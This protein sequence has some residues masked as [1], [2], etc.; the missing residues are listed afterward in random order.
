MALSETW[1]GTDRAVDTPDGYQLFRQDLTSHCGGVC[2]YLRSHYRASRAT[3]LCHQSKTLEILT[4]NVKAKRSISISVVYRHPKSTRSD[5]D[6][7]EDIASSAVA[8]NKVI[9]FLGDFNCDVSKPSDPTTSSLMRSFDSLGLHQLVK[10]PTRQTRL[11]STIIDLIY[12]GKKRDVLR[13]GVVPYSVSDHNIIYAVLRLKLPKPVKCS[14]TLRSLKKLDKDAYITDLALHDW[15]DCTRTRNVNAAVDAFTAGMNAAI[16]KH[17]PKKTVIIKSRPPAPWISDAIRMLMKDRERAKLRARNTG[18]QVHW[19]L[20]R[21]IRNEVNADISKAKQLH[22]ASALSEATTSKEK[23]QVINNLLCRKK[24]SDSN[25]TLPDLEDLN[26]YFA[27]ICSA[28]PSTPRTGKQH[29]STVETDQLWLQPVTPLDILRVIDAMPNKSSEG[30]DGINLQLLKFSL[31][32]TLPIIDHI[33][34]LSFSTATFPHQWKQA[35]VVPIYKKKGERDACSS[36]RPIA[37]LPVL[38]RITEKLVLH[39]LSAHML[40]NNTLTQHQHA[41]RKGH[42]TETALLEVCDIV[43]SAMD[44]QMVT[45]DVLVDLS[46]A[47]DKVDHAILL[48]KL[49]DYSI[50][51]PWFASYLASRSQAV[52]KPNH[53]LTPFRPTTCGVPQG[54]VLGPTLF[55]IYTS[56][57]PHTLQAR[58]LMYADDTQIITSYR[59]A[60]LQHHA[61]LLQNDLVQ[62]ESW[63]TANKLCI[64]AAKTQVITMGTSQQLSKLPG[65]ICDSLSLHNTSPDPVITANNLGVTFD[66]RLTWDDHIKTMCSRAN[67]AIIQLAR[68]RR[69]L[70]LETLRSTTLS[71]AMSHLHYCTNVWSV[72]TAK[73][74]APVQRCIRFAE[75]V[76]RCEL[77]SSDRIANERL[78]KLSAAARAGT[79]SHFINSCL[80]TNAR[81]NAIKPRAKSNSGQKVLGFRLV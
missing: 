73:A 5:L 31:P 3:L 20:Y 66:K 64:N 15:S 22:A 35:A 47:F 77:P 38:S 41:Y 43:Y 67:A 48:R 33:I 53:D 70:P 51:D 12:C 17:C 44:N 27:D 49:K 74:L 81:G 18:L 39:Q 71:L 10:Q 6:I 50:C 4:I 60:E 40:R 2:I 34:T 62:L 80:R 55:S 65:N 69:L 46:K 54:S 56:D 58:T 63:M 13:C 29:D 45:T 75:K 28:T 32:V 1:L 16:N 24:I 57:L 68:I 72:A 14:I 36:Y 30:I 61:Q 59:P 79:S 11:S 8:S 76:C 9:L 23:W 52:R 42:S 21:D 19:D 26:N 78:S 37:L 7:L 25:S